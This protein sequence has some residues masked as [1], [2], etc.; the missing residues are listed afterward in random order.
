MAGVAA[1]PD[2]SVPGAEHV[3]RW[4]GA[5]GPELTGT[6][7]AGLVPAEAPA[8][9]DLPPEAQRFAKGIGSI[10]RIASPEWRLNLTPADAAAPN[11]PV[12]VF[13]AEYR[14]SAAGGRWLHEAVYWLGHKANTDL[15][16]TFPS[17]A[18][19][20]S[21]AVDG[22]ETAPLQSEARRLW[23][24]LTGRPPV[25]RVRVRWRYAAEDLARPDLTQPTLQG[26]RDGPAGWTVFAPPGWEPDRAAGPAV[27][28]P[29]LI[30]AA[31][32]SWQRA[33]AH[34]RLSAAL[35]RQ[36]GGEADPALAEAQ[37]R[38]YAACLRARRM[39]D[40]ST[41]G[42]APAWPGG[43]TPVETLDDLLKRNKDLAGE[44]H[45]EAVRQEA[46][47]R[48]S[49]GG[50]EREADDPPPWPEEGR[51]LYARAGGGGAAPSWR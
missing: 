50:A 2:V 41:E 47:S 24:P 4:V 22:G 6:G 26:A 29:G 17:D 1:M 23:L 30:Q 35:A 14:A 20:L 31:A 10:W 8:G 37:R 46:E 11:A 18:E 48:A 13:L 19:V 42:S 39:L 21:V 51:P 5:A 34:Y 44:R 15:N 36:A 33:E 38:F 43:H 45:F 3:E 40:A 49:A 28:E 7:A 16:L 27:L 25:C 32:L 9:L 12:E